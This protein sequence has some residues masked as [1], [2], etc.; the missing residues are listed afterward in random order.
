MKIIS[1]DGKVIQSSRNLAGIR[2]YVAHNVIRTLHI[3]HEESNE[4]EASLNILFD[5]GA[6]FQTKFGSFT[7]LCGFVRRWRNVYG[8]PLVIDAVNQGEVSYNN[9]A[10]SIF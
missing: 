8:A 7:V 5:N 10:L 4:W 1:K 6:I 3:C 2:R 9:P